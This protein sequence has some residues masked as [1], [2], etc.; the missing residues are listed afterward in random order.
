MEELREEQRAIQRGW[1]EK[2]DWLRQCLDLQLFNR[3]AD[4]IDVATSGHEAF[5]DYADMGVGNVCKPA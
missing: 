5:L 3:E 2:E 1:Q 4:Q